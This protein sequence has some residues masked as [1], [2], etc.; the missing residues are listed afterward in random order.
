M[1]Y[2]NFAI[3]RVEE[4]V[5]RGY[6]VEDA[7]TEGVGNSFGIVFSAAAIMI[8]VVVVFAVLRFLPIQQLGFALALAVLL[9]TT[10]ILL[11]LLPAL[12]G[13]CGKYLWYFHSWLKWIPGGWKRMVEGATTQATA[14]APADN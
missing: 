11:V 12:M 3:T 2:L 5:H 7:I 6:N 13:V 14:A 4:L 8:A 10:V 1:D 9:D